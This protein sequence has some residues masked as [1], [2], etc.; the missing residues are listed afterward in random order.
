LSQTVLLVASWLKQV[1][2]RTQQ[3][4]EFHCVVATEQCSMIQKD[5]IT[6]HDPQGY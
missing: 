4:S 5:T 2:K 6:I 3:Y 1:L